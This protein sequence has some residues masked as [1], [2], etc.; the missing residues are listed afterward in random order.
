MQNV[1]MQLHSSGYLYHT[2]KD[3]GFGLVIPAKT[4]TL[5]L[6]REGY[7]NEK[8][9]IYAEVFNEIIL[10]KT[11]VLKTPALNKLSSLVQNV[12]ADETP[13]STSGNETYAS[14]VE[15]DFVNASSKP[16]TAI[17]LNVDRASYSNIRRFL[18]LSSMVPPD[19]V[20]IEE[21]LN[22]FNLYYSEPKD[23][24]T[25]E[26]STTL[27][28]CPWNKNNALL[29]AQVNSKKIDLDFVP[30]SHLVFL[31]DVSGS[32]DFP[33]RLPLLKSGFKTLVNHLRPADTV[34][35]V[36]YGGSVG[37]ALFPTCG[38]E[39]TKILNAI[40]NL[41]P[42]GS[43]PGE[44]GIKLAYSLARAHFITGGSNRVI[45]A[46][47]G[48]FNVGVKKEE[49]LEELIDK[50]RRDGIY[51]TCLGVGMG[52]YKDSKIQ[53]LAQRGNG[54]FAYL[55]S[56]IEME[57]VLL[58]E[59]M[60]TL[61][62]V[63]DDASLTVHFNPAL[64]KEYRVIGFDNKASALTDST[65][66]L[67]EGEISPGY[68]MLAAFE[69]VPAQSLKDG[70]PGLVDF[71]LHYKEPDLH[72]P[73]EMT[74]QPRLAYTPLGQLAPSDRFASAVVLFGLLLRNSKYVK[75]TSWNEVLSLARPAVNPNNASQV[76][77]LQLVEQAKRLY[78]S[79]KRKKEE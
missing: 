74:E 39:K 59:F 54:N 33:N 18:N 44:S 62:T 77:F 64:V 35:I 11:P 75:G 48:D 61:H 30:Q 12:P 10:K 22:Y 29:F 65:A 36:V 55:D 23:N 38:S 17:T 14:L 57:K 52:N 25:F 21:M 46:T 69:L 45:L 5:L 60:Q 28:D 53:T 42:G 13:L 71:T 56:Y 70:V 37:V 67:L 24:A 66:T 19:A 58:K 26:I 51:L 73:R 9:A 34:S 16:A 20:R 1:T 68:S 63:A 15:N 50:E 49:E 78:G 76:E 79:K 47:D 6:I 43:T 40:E 41:Q 7:E 72:T 32:M 8:R 4:D 31:I 3:G 2:G 27:T